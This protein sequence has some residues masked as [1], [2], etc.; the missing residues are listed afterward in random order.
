MSNVPDTF[1]IKVDQLCV[2]LLCF[3]GYVIYVH[4]NTITQTCF[5]GLYE[6]FF[7]NRNSLSK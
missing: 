3:L 7:G 1:K 4:Y 6:Q 5:V 2:L